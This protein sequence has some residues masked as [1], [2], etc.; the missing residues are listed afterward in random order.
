MTEF[1]ELLK[2]EIVAVIAFLAAAISCLFAPIVNYVDYIDTDLIGVLFGLMAVVAGFAENNVFKKLTELILSAAGDTRRLAD[3]LVMTVF[4]I[5][6]L[7]T[8]DVALIAFIPF[9]LMLYSEIG[10][11]PVY[12]IVLQT[13]AANL[14]STL[15]PFGNP[16]NLYLFSVSKMTSAEFFS[17][18]LPVTAVSL[19][20]LVLSLLFIKKEPISLKN[21][22]EKVKILN[23]RYLNLYAVLFILCVLAVFDIVDTISVFASVCVVVAIIQPK[24][25]SKVDYGLLVTFVCFFIF[26]G[27]IKNTPQI[28]EFMSGMIAGHEFES[29][30]AASQIIS[31]VPAA[32]MLSA[33]TDNWKA[34]LLGTDIGGLGT[35]IASLASLI[36]YKNYARSENADTGRFI[37]V[38]TLMNIIF[39]AVLYIIAKLFLLR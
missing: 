23:P 4:F 6:M 12:V 20:M 22:H 28:S 15:T 34:L 14:G 7:I 38:F 29:A 2:K 16:Q 5:S 30:L 19:G 24:I 21:D 17:I 39:L 27:N 36:T 26:V 13:I 9:T 35:L 37:M 18:T 3:V 11:S 32:I 10:K 8:N 1:K 33:F 31:N 25:F